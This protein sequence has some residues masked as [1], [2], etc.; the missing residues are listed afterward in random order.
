[1]KISL[2]EVRHIVRKLLE[3]LGTTC[4]KCGYDNPYMD[5]TESYVCRQCRVRDEKFGSSDD[6]NAEEKLDKSEFEGEQWVC[7]NCGYQD[8]RATKMNV[9]M[10]GWECEGCGYER[11]PDEDEEM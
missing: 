10:G 8:P 7:P 2:R 9:K 3:T 4:T 6:W 5:P 1:M 11:Y